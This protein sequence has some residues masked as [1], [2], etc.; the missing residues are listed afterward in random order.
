M[1]SQLKLRQQLKYPPFVNLIKIHKPNSRKVPKVSLNS[2]KDKL[3]E[4][5]VEVLI[6]SGARNAKYLIAKVPE[7]NWN[8][9]EFSAII[10]SIRAEYIIEINPKK[11]L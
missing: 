3:G 11:V 4:F 10:T 6:R 8:K 2:I 1:E 7:E 9:N 5:S